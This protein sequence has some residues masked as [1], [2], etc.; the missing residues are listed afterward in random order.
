MF[1]SSSVCLRL[2]VSSCSTSILIL[3][4]P[5]IQM[6]PAGHVVRLARCERVLGF[7]ALLTAMLAEVGCEYYP[8]Y[9]VHEEYRAYGQGQFMC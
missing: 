5:L 3:D 8:E 2:L 6:N 4:I 9:I 1:I 7:P